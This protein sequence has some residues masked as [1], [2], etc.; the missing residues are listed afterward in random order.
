MGISTLSLAI[1][2]LN[3]TGAH[4]FARWVTQSPFPGGTVHVDSPWPN[5]LTRQWQAW[6][7]LFSPLGDLDLP[8][9][10]SFLE[11]ALLPLNIAPSSPEDKV[12]QRLMQE[13]GHS[14]WQWVFQDSL[15]QTLAGS[16]GLASGRNQP[17]RFRLDI[18]DPDLVTLPWE[19]MQPDLG[20]PAISLD[21][22]ILFS[23]TTHQVAAL[24][25]RRSQGSIQIL[26][27][28]GAC[29]SPVP[30]P[31][32]LP[33]SPENSSSLDLKKEADLI[34]WIL[35][36]ADRSASDH[37]SPFPPA[38]VQVT[39]LVQPQL[40]ELI[41]ALDSQQYNVF[42]YGGHGSLDVNG[43][44]LF[45]NFQEQ[46]IN[47]MELA[48]V[49]V[50]N[51]IT[52]SVFNACWGAHPQ[53]LHRQA[54]R[55]SSLAE[56]LI[57]HGVPA[58]LAMRDAI[59]NQE[60]LCFSGA[61]TQALRQRL[62]V[63]RAAQI[64]RQQLLTT[65]GFNHPAWTIPVLYMHP[66]FDGELISLTVPDD[67]ILPPPPPPD[68]LAYLRSPEILGASWPIHGKLMRVGR[69]PHENDLVTAEPWVSQRHAQIIRL[70]NPA[71]T[72][73]CSEFSYILRDDSRYGTLIFDQDEWR[74]IHRGEVR[75]SSGMKLK[76]GSY[77]GQTYEFVVN[78]PLENGPKG[79]DP[80]A[81]NSDKGL[82]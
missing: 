3:A 43:G 15:S 6:R 57:H 77:Q 75:L 44:L 41:T 38:P 46:G 33:A 40:T 8:V 78:P 35:K 45:L 61:F 26:L 63:D 51:R 59:T 74:T 69:N 79:S 53:S 9:T 27:V 52:L 39:T 19:I 71:T 64:A 37:S 25:P 21:P 82:L 76:F 36:Q 7:S 60:A 47:G 16:Q 70:E 14:L 31:T 29:Q 1:K 4:N 2:R 23:R 80:I 55:H 13:F 30:S 67:T 18:D 49:L 65:Y 12:C 48:Q 73:T 56:V 24:A 62:P 10:D 20:K 11:A 72:P 5:S 58:V 81:N 32:E 42:F 50:R 17:L 28:L 54:L 34:T 68:V 66:E 22:H